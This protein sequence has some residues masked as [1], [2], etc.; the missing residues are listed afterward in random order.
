VRVI[1]GYVPQRERP[2][3]SARREAA[4]AD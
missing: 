1:G 2:R 4:H 3:W